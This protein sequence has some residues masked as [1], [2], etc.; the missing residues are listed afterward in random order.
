[1][2]KDTLVEYLDLTKALNIHRQH[3]QSLNSFEHRKHWRSMI[4]ELTPM[5]RESTQV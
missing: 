1:M 2:E 5:V 4:P 3:M